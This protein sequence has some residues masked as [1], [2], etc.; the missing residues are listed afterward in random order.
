MQL[1]VTVGT[2]AAPQC[3]GASAELS[4]VSWG[5]LGRDAGVHGCEPVGI[6]QR[7]RGRVQQ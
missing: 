7:G 6:R 5:V 1:I 2:F 4:Y 3:D